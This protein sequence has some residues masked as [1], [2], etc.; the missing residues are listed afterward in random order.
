MGGK[1][2][3][4]LFRDQGKL[5]QLIVYETKNAYEIYGWDI[6]S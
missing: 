1:S 2:I 6:R 4:P 3:F 5:R